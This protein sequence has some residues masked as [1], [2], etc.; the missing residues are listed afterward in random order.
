MPSVAGPL[1]TVT[2]WTC[3]L[4]LASPKG[5]VPSGLDPVP[6]CSPWCPLPGPRPPGCLSTLPLEASVAGRC[7]QRLSDYRSL[8]QPNFLKR[9]IKYLPDHFLLP[10]EDNGVTST[11]AQPPLLWEVTANP[12]AGTRACGGRWPARGPQP[13]LPRS[14]TW[15]PQCGNDQRFIWC[16]KLQNW[17]LLPVSISTEKWG[18]EY[19]PAA[20]TARGP[21]PAPGGR[22][23]QHPQSLAAGVRS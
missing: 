19:S 18:W 17:H 13:R 2:V 15:F 10:A 21:L 1:P 14:P 4:G 20:P 6:S 16:L 12:L 23:H 8:S 5:A 7:R 3:H 11:A 9:H 22:T